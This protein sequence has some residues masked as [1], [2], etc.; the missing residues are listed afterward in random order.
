MDDSVFIATTTDPGYSY[1]GP[2][3]GDLFTAEFLSAIASE[4]PVEMAFNMACDSVK[5]LHGA[6][7]PILYD[8]SGLAPTSYVGSWTIRGDMAPVI[9]DHSEGMT[10]AETS[11]P[12]TVQLWAR[13]EDDVMVEQAYALIM[14]P[15][16]DPAAEP[17]TGEGGL[18]KQTLTRRVGGYWT[19]SFEIPNPGEYKVAYMAIDNVGNVTELAT[20]TYV[21]ASI[22]MEI[23]LNGYTFNPG[24]TVQVSVGYE[25][26]VGVDVD[27]DF[28]LVIN[29]PNSDLMLFVNGMA[30][31]SFDTGAPFYSG[32][33]PPGEMP[34]MPIHWLPIP[35]VGLDY[36]LYTWYAVCTEPGTLNIMGEGATAAMDLQ[37]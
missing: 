4:K 8:S 7:E 36:G 35:E 2:K 23:A 29:F 5:A 13:T 30:G 31:Y 18:I 21:M 37:P 10:Y 14:M 17:F 24:D 26:N 11:T 27:V 1:P 3:H 33:L 32:V 20:T 34:L 16:Y 28:Y 9:V 19:G 22:D 12:P 25:N 15:A 6:Q